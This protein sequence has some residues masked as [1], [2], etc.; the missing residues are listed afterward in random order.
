MQKKELQLLFHYISA[1]FLLYY[2]PSNLKGTEHEKL[3]ETFTVDFIQN[4]TFSQFYN[5]K[6][7]AKC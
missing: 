1:A 6:H 5:K 2:F 4:V 7:T 3:S